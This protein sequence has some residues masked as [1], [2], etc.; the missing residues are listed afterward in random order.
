MTIDISREEIEKEAERY[1]REHP[2]VL[3]YTG[4]CRTCRD[5]KSC[6]IFQKHPQEVY[7]KW[8]E[9]ISQTIERLSQEESRTKVQSPQNLEYY[10]QGLRHYGYGSNIQGRHPQCLKTKRLVQEFL[11]QRA[12]DLTVE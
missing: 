3:E 8:H 9:E 5:W 1:V 6:V 4:I 11:D 7:Q 10:Y 12:E 2:K